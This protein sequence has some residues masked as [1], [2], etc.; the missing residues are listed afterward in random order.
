MHFLAYA[1]MEQGNYAAAKKWCDQ[2]VEHV[3]P[4]VPHMQMLEAFFTVPYGVEVRFARW[5]DVMKEKEPDAKATPIAAATWHF[6]RAMAYADRGDTDAA[7]RE[8]AAMK[9]V[10]DTM[11]PDMGFA[12]LNKAHHVM[13]IAMHTLDGKIA[14]E[15]KQFDAAARHY[16]EAVAL[17]DKLNYIEPPDWLLRSRESLGGVL[18]AKGDFAGAEKIFREDLERNP[19]S[20]RSL[21][22]LATALEKQKKDYDAGLVRRQFDAAWKNADTKL[23]PDDL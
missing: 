7:Q 11:P 8:R 1:E 12:M 20:A 13:D 2:L 17:Q 5:D 22:G 23:S 18:L 21:L 15:A 16:R 3:R 9:A 19:R 10:V 4:H 14:A 6:A